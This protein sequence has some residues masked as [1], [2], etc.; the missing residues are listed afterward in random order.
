[1]NLT[2]WHYDLSAANAWNRVDGLDLHAEA[3]RL[4]EWLFGHKKYYSA[5][6]T[7][8]PAEHRNRILVNPALRPEDLAEYNRDA[9]VALAATPVNGDRPGLPETRPDWDAYFMRL[10]HLAAT[11]ATCDRKH[12]GAVVVR[13]NR[14]L[15]TGYNGSPPGLAHC[16]DAGH[17]LLRQADG[18]ENCVR[19]IHAEM[20]A[21]LQAAATGVAVKGATLFTNTYPCWNCAKALLGAGIAAVAT[22]ADYNNDPRVEAAFKA[23]GVRLYTVKP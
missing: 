1:M 4:T 12:V 7:S 21:I 3:R 13:D 9:V 8:E 10:A 6:V 11:R 15:A 19:T 23:A 20:N 5:G 2:F 18:R 22:D 16:D 14:V 17:D